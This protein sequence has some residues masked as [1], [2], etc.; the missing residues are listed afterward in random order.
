[1]VP[2]RE[3]A[4]GS[5]ILT[6]FSLPFDASS[7]FL[8]SLAFFSAFF[9]TTATAVPF[10]SVRRFF[11]GCGSSSSELE[12]DSDADEDEGDVGFVFALEDF[13]SFLLTPLAATFG[14]MTSSASDSASSSDS[15]PESVSDEL[16]DELDFASNFL[17]AFGDFFVGE[18]S[19]SDSDGEELDD[20]E[21]EDELDFDATAG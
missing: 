6:F 11:F 3:A 9:S 17:V 14:V 1:M 2:F 20:E 5:S 8:V 10:S 18:A 13:P 4:G 15:V 21:A 12:L 16:D 19:A 7:G